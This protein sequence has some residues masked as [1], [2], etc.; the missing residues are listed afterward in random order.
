MLR[1][2]SGLAALTP[3]NLEM[4]IINLSKDDRFNVEKKIR[5]VLEL[6]E[7]EKSSRRPLNRHGKNPRKFS[8]QVK[9]SHGAAR[10]CSS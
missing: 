8:S 5:F 2:D 3:Y 6:N 4:K 10:R 1:L 7:D 9:S